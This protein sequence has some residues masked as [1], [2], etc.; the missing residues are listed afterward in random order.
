MRIQDRQGSLSVGRQ[1]GVHIA[2]QREGIDQLL[3]RRPKQGPFRQAFELAS[4]YSADSGENL[5]ELGTA[6]QCFSRRAGEGS[7]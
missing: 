7:G 5:E 4:C 6:A 3:A 2:G 1:R